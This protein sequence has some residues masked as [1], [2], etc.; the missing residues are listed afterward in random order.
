MTAWCPGV[1][2]GLTHPD[3]PETALSQLQVQ[4]QRLARDLPGVF[5]QSLSLGLQDG[6]DVREAVAQA[7]GVLCRVTKRHFKTHRASLTRRT[8]GFSFYIYIRYMLF[9][10]DLT[11]FT[12]SHLFV[13]IFFIII[14]TSPC[15]QS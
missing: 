13:N 10:F 15:V 7:V 11:L 5:G 6:A 4:T 9:Y 3:L 1:C 14:C 2:A 12:R 8:R